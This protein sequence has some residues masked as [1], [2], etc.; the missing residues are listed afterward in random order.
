MMERMVKERER[1]GRKRSEVI[2]KG[3][4]EGNGMDSDGIKWEGSE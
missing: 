4:K 2:E 1:K 3:G